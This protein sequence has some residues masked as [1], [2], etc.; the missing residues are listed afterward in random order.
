MAST[1]PQGAN[2]AAWIKEAKSNPLT[3]DDA[4]MPKPEADEVLVKNSAVAVNPVDWKIQDSGHIIQH[5]PNVLGTDV[6]GE[7]VEVGS[8]VKNVKKGDRVLAHCIGLAT[9]K[10]GD[11]GFQL[12]T[13]A[14]AIL[15]SVIPSSTSF[16][17]AAVLPLALS[18]AAAGL[19][20]PGFLEL[21][22]PTCPPKDSGKVILVWGGSSSVGS[23]ALQ[24]CA[25]SGV[26][27]VTTASKH[28]HEYCTK[29][30]AKAV[31]D[32]NSPSV[33][34]DILSAIE[35]TGKDFAGIYDSISL[36][37]S[38]K[39]C[40]AVLEKAGGS[41]NMAT[42]LPPGSSK[43]DGYNVNG[44]F[45]ISVANQFKQVGDAVWQKWVPAAL[46]DGSLKCLPE[47]LVVGSGLES[48]QKGLDVQ[49]KGVS[50]KKVVIE[51]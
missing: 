40:Y 11:N 1:H 17:E 33:V 44:V 15:T 46:E 9:G 30:G 21:P 51:L 3:V 7:V 25:G 8:N 27:V 19:Y 50:A 32:Y 31:I 10:P 23:T 28:N 5:Y 48:V 43:P 24:L 2:K 36:P 4:P 35:S 13:T 49:K 41:K 12:Y 39:H 20:Q 45:A 42:V 29:L 16:A 38:F 34:D 18:T 14:P 22:Y 6:A 47:P 26:D 37:E